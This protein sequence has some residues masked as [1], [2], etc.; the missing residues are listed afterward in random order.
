MCSDSDRTSKIGRQVL[1]EPYREERH[2]R[3]FAD[4]KRLAPAN[5]RRERKRSRS[6]APSASTLWRIDKRKPNEFAR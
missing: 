1:R 5:L 2:R 3:D 6:I 4:R